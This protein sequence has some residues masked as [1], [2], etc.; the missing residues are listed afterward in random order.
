MKKHFFLVLAAAVVMGICAASVFA[1]ATTVPTKVQVG[2]LVLT[3]DGDV[4]PKLLPRH[5]FAP[6]GFWASGKLEALDHSHPPA[7][8]S[9][10]FEIDRDVRIDVSEFPACPKGRLVAQSTTNA[11]RACP[12]AILGRGSGEVEVAFPEQPRIHA[13]G[14]VLLFN[15]GERGDVTTFYLHTYVSIPAPTAIVITSTVTRAGGKPYGT[16]IETEVPRI[17]GGAGSI[18]GFELRANRYS[19]FRGKRRSWLFARC[20]DGRFDARGRV[21]FGDGTVMAATIVRSCTASD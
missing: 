11:V 13:T 8:E 2:N 1:A 19:V 6:I 16:R 21:D 18:T 15:G 14:P 12:G 5:E 7:W 3:F 4:A 9:G 17:A 20:P 10:W